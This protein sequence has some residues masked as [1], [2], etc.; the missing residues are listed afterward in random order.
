MST[1]PRPQRRDSRPKQNLLT[2]TNCEAFPPA[3]NT[4][5]QVPFT[6][7]TVGHAECPGTGPN[8][9]PARL[10]ILPEQWHNDTTNEYA[11]TVTLV[12]GVLTVT[13]PSPVGDNDHLTVAGITG[14]TSDALLAAFEAASFNISN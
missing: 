6:L 13:F 12:A 4:I 1:R 11:T 14:P 8:P 7:I 2:P 10:L 3:L 9:A 5:T